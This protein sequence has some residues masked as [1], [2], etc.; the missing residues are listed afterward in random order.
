MRGTV[1]REVAR[2][3]CEDADIL[4]AERRY[5]GAI[6]LAG[7]AIECHLKWAVCDRKEET[8]LPKNY[9][10]HNWDHLVAGAGLRTAIDRQ[11]R[12]TALYGALAE[13]WGPALRYNTRQYSTTEAGRLYSETKQLYQFLKEL[14]P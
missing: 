4:F 13:Q 7:Y 1:F 9:E 12:M 8:H 6:Y 2:Q 10:T 5:N 3:R 14:A 11:P